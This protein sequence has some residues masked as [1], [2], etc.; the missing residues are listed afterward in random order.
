M[1]FSGALFP[2]S[3]S[4]RLHPPPPLP[5]APAPS[6]T[7][8]HPGRSPEK[9]RGHWSCG[10][11]FTLDGALC[12]NHPGGVLP[13]LSQP[14]LQGLFSKGSEA[15]AG[16]GTGGNPRFCLLGQPRPLGAR[17]GEPAGRARGGPSSG[18]PPWPRPPPSMAR[19]AISLEG[20]PP[21]RPTP[22]P[23]FTSQGLP[24]VL[25]KEPLQLWKGK[26]M[27]GKRNWG[28]EDKKN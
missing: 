21:R 3:H 2:R 5:E 13:A 1:A 6:R 22:L 24:P 20:P 16:R 8:T 28:R 18:A 19:A 14:Q 12:A 9:L 10:T 11:S 23:A 7:R 27:R 15:K 26:Q 17:S 4:V 25:Q